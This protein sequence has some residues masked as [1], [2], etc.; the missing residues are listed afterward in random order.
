MNIEYM[1]KVKV[2]KWVPTN[3]QIRT[4]IRMIET[5]GKVVVT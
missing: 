3:V 2:A 5:Y 1:K 4:F